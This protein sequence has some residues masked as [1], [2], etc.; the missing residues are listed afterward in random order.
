MRE[1]GGGRPAAAT[2]ELATGGAPCARD[3][4]DWS[5]SVRGSDAPWS[6][7]EGES[8]EERDGERRLIGL[9]RCWLVPGQPEYLS[10]GQR[11]L[12]G[13]PAPSSSLDEACV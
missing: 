9:S 11:P 2:I 13:H 3:A 8:L 7:A 4:T 6:H 1:I 5:L 10:H 12:C